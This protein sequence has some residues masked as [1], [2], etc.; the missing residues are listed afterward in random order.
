MKD[1]LNKFSNNNK[2]AFYL[3]IINVDIL[4]IN[5]I[6]KNKKMKKLK[7]KQMRLLIILID[8]IIN[9]KINL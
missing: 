5:L 4:W 9:K 3:F 8:Y 6:R 2:I 1:L 7:V